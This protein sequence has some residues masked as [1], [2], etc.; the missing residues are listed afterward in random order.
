MAQRCG[1]P[2]SRRPRGQSIAEAIPGSK[3]DPSNSP[4]VPAF[5][6]RQRILC[7]S[8]LRARTAL[9]DSRREQPHHS[10]PLRTPATQGRQLGRPG[11][12]RRHPAH[13]VTPTPGPICADM[14]HPPWSVDRKLLGTSKRGPYPAR[15]APAGQSTNALVK[16]TPWPRPCPAE[17]DRSGRPRANSRA[18]GSR[19]TREA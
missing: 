7:A 4:L 15:P 13:C 3:P 12:W 1:W 9:R 8:A 17:P 6:S 19:A 14:E 11:V 16:T 18:R 5:C 2:R 10:H